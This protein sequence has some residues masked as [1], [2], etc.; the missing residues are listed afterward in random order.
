AP[1]GAR[2]SSGLIHS[3]LWDGGIATPQ[4]G[5]QGNPPESRVPLQ[6]LPQFGGP[7][8]GGNYNPQ[9]SHP[10]SQRQNPP[11]T[12]DVPFPGRGFP[13]PLDANAP[14]KETQSQKDDR[15]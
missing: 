9:E 12:H 7:I 8:F 11:R 2:P 14:I 3:P 15:D 6:G 1:P 13:A 5:R 10:P 4:Q